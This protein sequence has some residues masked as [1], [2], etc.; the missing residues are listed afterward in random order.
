M[1][2]NQKRKQQH[3]QRTAKKAAKAHAHTKKMT[4][5]VTVPA[6]PPLVQKPEKYE[7]FSDA[8]VAACDYTYSITRLRPE[9]TGTRPVTLG[10]A[11]LVGKNRA[12]TCGHCINDPKH[13]DMALANHKNGDSYIFIQKDQN[14]VMHTA[15]ITPKLNRDLFIYPEI[16]MAVFYLPDGFYKMGDRWVKNPANHLSLATAFASIGEDV[17][18]LGYPMQ[19]V[20]FT[21]GGKVDPSSVIIRSDKGVVNTRYR[22]TQTNTHMYEFTIAFNPG[23]SG[24]PILRQDTGS[25]I[26]MVHG[27]NSFPIDLGNGNTIWN[28]YSLGIASENMKSFKDTHSLSFD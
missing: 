23:N 4:K 10:T 25:V 17:G 1:S 16:D 21:A 12:M 9:G 18:V 26:G 19:S 8:A 3:Q 22:A 11:F 24:G 27:F 5:K 20:G 13:P 7:K 2:G 28:A 14:G 15:A 6:M